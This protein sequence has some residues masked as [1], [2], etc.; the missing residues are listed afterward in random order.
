MNMLAKEASNNESSTFVLI[1]RN[2]KLSHMSTEG[3]NLVTFIGSFHE[4]EAHWLKNVTHA[5]IG[6]DP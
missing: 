4:N 1:S 6:K 2:G 3:W 5:Y